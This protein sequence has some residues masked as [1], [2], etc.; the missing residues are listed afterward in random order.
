MTVEPLAKVAEHV[1]PQSMPAGELVT[2]PEPLPAFVADRATG[3]GVPKLTVTDAPVLE[4]EFTVTDRL[5]VG[6]D[7][8]LA[9]PSA[10]SVNVPGV[11][12]VMSYR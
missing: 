4:A 12:G 7:Q 6:S 3:G 5:L 9:T 8:V 1:A 2:V 10:A 11:P